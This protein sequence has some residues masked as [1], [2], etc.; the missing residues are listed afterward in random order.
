MLKDEILNT[1]KNA[2]V[3]SSVDYDEMTND[4]IR[5][6]AIYYATILRKD[7]LSYKQVSAVWDTWP[8]DFFYKFRK[9]IKT[10][11]DMGDHFWSRP[12][13]NNIRYGIG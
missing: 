10:S 8:P 3:G 11:A 4:D 13:D 7:D 2:S 5:Q 1:V 9:M 6:L 12:A